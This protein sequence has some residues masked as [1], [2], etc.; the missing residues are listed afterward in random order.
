VA[1]VLACIVVVT[2]GLCLLWASAQAAVTIA[3]AEVKDGNLEVTRGGLSPRV[4]EGLQ[5]VIARPRVRRARIRILRSKSRARVEV[6]GDLTE[7]QI[8]QIRNIVGVLKLPEITRGRR[9]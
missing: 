5:H 1:V 6:R 7:V 8:Q 3:F 2:G 4:I 9:R